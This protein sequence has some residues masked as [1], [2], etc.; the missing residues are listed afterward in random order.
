MRPVMLNLPDVMLK[1]SRHIYIYIYIY[2]YVTPK[3]YDCVMQNLYI[4]S[5]RIIRKIRHNYLQCFIIYR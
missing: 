1:V 3:I 5:D 4:F 2:I